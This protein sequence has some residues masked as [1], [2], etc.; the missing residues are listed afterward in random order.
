RYNPISYQLGSVWTHDNAILAAGLVRY[1]LRDEAARVLDALFAAASAFERNRL[2]ELFC[3]LPRG[4]AGPVPYER[5]NSPQAWAAAAPVL[6]VQL[7]LGLVPDVP[8]GKIYLSPWLPAW[9]P[10]LEVLG[11]E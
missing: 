1:G 5:A 11:I 10:S 3:G 6:A 9:L 7:F 2:P 4:L 8:R